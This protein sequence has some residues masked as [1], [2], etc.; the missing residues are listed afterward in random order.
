M[1]TSWLLFFLAC[2]L[3]SAWLAQHKG[4]SAR[5]WF[6]LGALLGVVALGVLVRQPRRTIREDDAAR[7]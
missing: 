1:S 7:L 6:W 4:Y 5:I 2:G 3:T